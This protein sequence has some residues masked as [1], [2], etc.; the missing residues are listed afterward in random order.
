VIEGGDDFML[1]VQDPLQFEFPKQGFTSVPR[2][3]KYRWSVAFES[4]AAVSQ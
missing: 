4:C 3:F 1:I 2:S